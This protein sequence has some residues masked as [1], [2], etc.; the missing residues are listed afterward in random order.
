MKEYS[1][2]VH[3]EEREAH[4]AI[5]AKLLVVTKFSFRLFTDGEDLLQ[6]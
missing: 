1:D 6:I 4:A 3:R 2:L 5:T